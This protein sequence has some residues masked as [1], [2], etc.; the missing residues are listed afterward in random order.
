MDRVGRGGRAGPWLFGLVVFQEEAGDPETELGEGPSGREGGR[1]SAPSPGR[2]RAVHVPLLSDRNH[3]A[4]KRTQPSQ[5]RLHPSLCRSRARGPG[6]NGRTNWD[7]RFRRLMRE[8]KRWL[9]RRPR[10]EVDI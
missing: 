8:G 1:V 3:R 10:A 2:R 4:H 5:Q 6:S 7:G 9:V